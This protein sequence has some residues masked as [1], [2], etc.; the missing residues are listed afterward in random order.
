MRFDFLG[1]PPSMGVSAAL[2]DA[3]IA[4]L[5]G[6]FWAAL[7]MASV[8]AATEWLLPA[9]L[10]GPI[11]QSGWASRSQGWLSSRGFFPPELDPN[12]NRSFCWT[13]GRA[14][15]LLP[16]LDRSQSYRI[17]ISAEAGRPP[18]SEHL[19]RL[20]LV[21]DRS[22]PL[23]ER[24][25]DGPTRYT[26]DVPA[27]SAEGVVVAIIPSNT[28]RPGARDSRAL[29]VR[30]DDVILTATSGHFRLTRMTSA[31]V[32]LAIL[33]FALGVMLCD[34]GPVSLALSGIGTFA[35]VLFVIADGAFIG[36]FVGRLVSIGL[37][38]AVAGIA[39]A[40]TRWRWQ[41]TADVRGWSE[42]AAVVVALTAVKLALFVHPLAAIGDGVFHAHRASLVHSGHYFFTSVTPKPFFEFPYPVALYVIAQPFWRF[43]PSQFEVVWLL[44]GIVVITDAAV[45]LALYAAALRQWNS[46]RTALFCAVLWAAARAPFLALTNAN[47]T[48]AF[49]QALFSG[50]LALLAW[51]AAGS[52]VS[53]TTLLVAGACFSAGFLAHF[54]TVLV[55]LPILAAVGASLAWWGGAHLRRCG[56][57]VLMVGLIAVAA[58]YCLYYSHFNALYV[59]TLKAMMARSAEAVSSSKVTAPWTVKLQRWLA[60]TGD[61][62]GLPGIPVIVAAASGLFL[63][64]RQH[65]RDALTLVFGG[66]MAAW[67]ALT[68]LETLLPLEL[69]ANLAVAPV[70]VCLGAYTLSRLVES[71]TAGAVL[72]AAWGLLIAWD[73]VAVALSFLGLGRS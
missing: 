44:R 67:I 24:P 26:V 13:R 50:G 5:V 42:A 63:L 21:V 9:T 51:Q 35:I 41:P 27:R 36:T 17:G 3:S 34:G 47:L 56:W 12:S 14:K 1:R 31:K 19:D 66:W 29:G 57:L 69:R 18:G 62:Y 73:G 45:A 10:V 4:M 46:R 58:S 52:R 7:G 64:L 6:A 32:F 61:D 68:V 25:P 59:A 38:T 11:A 71:S 72:G 20:E 55:G 22:V 53:R 39:V 40:R 65:P 48:N 49:G 60:G 37:G 23:E 8:W 28:F 16:H 70:F 43:F 15:L 2:R 30:V 54:G 33:L